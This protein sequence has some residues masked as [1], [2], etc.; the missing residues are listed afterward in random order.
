MNSQQINQEMLQSRPALSAYIKD[1]TRKVAT[2]QK[3]L[4]NMSK[5]RFH[6]CDSPLRLIIQR[7]ATFQNHFGSKVSHAFASFFVLK[8]A[9]KKVN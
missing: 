8:S 2:E 9:G 4:I 1:Y 6:Y 3:N 5:S 7:D